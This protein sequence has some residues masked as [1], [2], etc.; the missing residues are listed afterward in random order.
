MTNQS[1]NGFMLTRRGCSRQT[2]AL[3]LLLCSVLTLQQP[4]FARQPQKGDAA[5]LGKTHFGQAGEPVID[6]NFT[7]NWLLLQH[8]AHQRAAALSY[9]TTT[10]ALDTDDAVN[11]LPESIT[12][13]VSNNPDGATL[14][15]MAAA[16][17]NAKVTQLCI[18]AGLDD[19]IIA[20]DQANLFS[21]S[22]LCPDADIE[23]E[24]NLLQQAISVR[25]YTLSAALL[26]YDALGNA[27]G[28]RTINN[29]LE[30]LAAAFAIAMA[31]VTPAYS[32][33]SNCRENF[34]KRA[35]IENACNHI[36]AAMAANEHDLTSKLMALELQQLRAESS[37]ATGLAQQ[38][39]QQRKQIQERIQCHASSIER[40]MQQNP[41]TG[42]SEYVDLLSKYGEDKAMQDYARRHDIECRKHT[43]ATSMNE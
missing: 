35:A 26:W 4:G 20:H 39:A 33:I 16:C 14:A 22:L 25:V 17:S 38:L 8:S 21:R 7:A 36:I 32:I 19:A 40:H 15:W 13:A 29:E 30:R 6:F 2:A 28:Q 42:V 3:L 18:D 12:E 9:M 10:L 24:Y 31:S 37:G 1:S 27:P 43:E 23:Q 11:R 41:A 5:A 34:A